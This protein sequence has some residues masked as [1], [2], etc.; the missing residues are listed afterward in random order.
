MTAASPK[1]NSARAQIVLWGA[2]REAIVTLAAALATLACTF[3]LDRGPGS[4]V[5]GVV[6]CVSL[7]RSQL[8]RDGRHRLETAL[9]LPA[10]G[11][12]AI[13]V[14]SLLRD[15]PWFGALAFVACMTLSIWLRRF[16]LTARRIGSLIA[17]PFIALLVTPR[18]D[19]VSSSVIP[20]ALVPIVIA[21][22]ALFWVS[23][24]HSVARSIGFLPRAARAEA[25]VQCQLPREGT[26]KPDAVTRMALQMA[27]ALSTAFIVGYWFFAERWTWIVL[28]AFIVLSGN[29]GRLDVAYKSMQRVGGAAV[30][31]AIALYTSVHVGH[32]DFPAA[33]ILA[34]LFFGIW[35]RPIGYQWWALFITIA[36]GLLQGFGEGNSAELLLQRMEEITIGAGIGVAAAS[37]VLPVR[38]TAVLRSRLANALAALGVA[39]DPAIPER[40][41]VPF[42]GAVDSVQQL[43]PSFRVSRLITSSARRVQPADWIDALLDCRA[44]AIELIDSGATPPEVRRAVGAARKALLEP[45]ALT[46]A[47]RELRRVLGDRILS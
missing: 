23:L 7:S 1:P 18:I 6:L 5:L 16:G 26:L 38:S 9:V 13:G 20:A 36:L 10:V 24:L 27:V 30:G 28:T 41:S 35:L 12:S 11:L 14:G 39:L 29:R 4:A 46:A 34:S 17:L 43:A 15:M 33:A 25:I 19:S 42:V 37:S 21:L 2:L 22:L 31:T 3:A 8:D 45:A 32:G 44:A 40:T 47:L